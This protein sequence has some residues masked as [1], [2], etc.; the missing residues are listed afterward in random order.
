MEL[1]VLLLLFFLAS[2]VQQAS[3]KKR[4]RPGSGRR[5]AARVRSA[6]AEPV[7]GR[8]PQGFRDLLQE[9]RRAL[10]ESEAAARG[11]LPGESGPV[12]VLDDDEDEND[13]EE[14]TSL[15]VEPRVVS[16]EGPAVRSER[17][18]F[19]FDD[20]A[21]ALVRRRVEWAEHQARGRRPGDHAAFDDRIRRPTPVKVIEPSRAAELRRMMV[22]REVL[23]RP[24]A[25]RDDR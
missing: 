19:G 22:W 2:L 15:E 1:I 14:R 10:E 3:Q 8:Q 13:I 24:V 5:P 6:R 12:A 18:V 16:L 17:P 9:M 4:G 25:L 7:A 23:G 11:R 21:E 20:E